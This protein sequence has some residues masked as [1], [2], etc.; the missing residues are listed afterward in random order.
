VAVTLT[1]PMTVATAASLVDFIWDDWPWSQPIL[2]LSV[3]KV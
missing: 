3:V 1:V 2:S